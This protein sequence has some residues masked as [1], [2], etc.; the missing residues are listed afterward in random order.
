M[1][2]GEDVAVKLNVP[3]PV[4][5]KEQMKEVHAAQEGM[6]REAITEQLQQSSDYVFDPLTAPK[7]EHF[8]VD[9]GLKLSCEGANHPNHHIW[10]RQK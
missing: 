1:N 5:Y 9:R 2:E 10:K 4:P 3:D 8:W 7:V 6:S